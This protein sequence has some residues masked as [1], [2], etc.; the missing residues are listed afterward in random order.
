LTPQTPTTAP[1][2]TAAQCAHERATT[3]KLSRTDSSLKYF[4]FFRLFWEFS[5][6]WRAIPGYK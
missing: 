1:G 6:G 2:T 5:E 4:Q 3:R